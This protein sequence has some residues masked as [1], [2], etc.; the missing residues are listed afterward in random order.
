[1]VVQYVIVALIIAAALIFAG[2]SLYLRTR[3]FSK[4]SGCDADCGCGG[5]SKKLSSKPV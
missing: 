3:S 2:R 4:K 1:M 5:K